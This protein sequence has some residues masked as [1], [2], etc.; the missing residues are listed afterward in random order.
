MDILYH[1][2]YNSEVTIKMMSSFYCNAVLKPN[3]IY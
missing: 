2:D 3:S 1:T